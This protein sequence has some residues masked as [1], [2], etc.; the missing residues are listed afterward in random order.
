MITVQI[1]EN[2]AHAQNIIN[3]LRTLPFVHFKNEQKGE[4]VTTEPNEK[5][6]K[7]IKEAH[8]RKNIKTFDDANTFLSDLKS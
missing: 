8:E 6:K 7:I 3:H 5:T 1:E 4:K 2:N